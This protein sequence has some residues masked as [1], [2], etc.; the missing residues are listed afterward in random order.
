MI[1][2][3]DC[4]HLAP[5]GTCVIK[6]KLCTECSQGKTEVKHSTDPCKYYSISG[7]C[8]TGLKD[9]PY[10]DC[11]GDVRRC[12]RVSFSNISATGSDQNVVDVTALSPGKNTR[13]LKW[14]NDPLENVERCSRTNPPGIVEC[15]GRLANCVFMEIRGDE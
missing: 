11:C 9:Y 1:K 13:C 14:F 15:G 8:C 5:C 3:E 4:P 6:N 10:V 2:W 12:E 7:R